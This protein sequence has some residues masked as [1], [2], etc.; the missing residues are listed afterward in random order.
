MI[1]FYLRTNVPAQD[2]IHHNHAGSVNTSTLGPPMNSLNRSRSRSPGSYQSIID[3]RRSVSP[4]FPRKNLMPP[5]NRSRSPTPNYTSTFSAKL[6]TTNRSPQHRNSG[7]SSLP[8]MS[9]SPTPRK[10]HVASL[11]IP[12]ESK[13]SIQFS[14]SF[15]TSPLIETDFLEILSKNKL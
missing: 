5:P 13:V 6:A 7:P 10:H 12:V 15:V 2:S 9:I 4:N 11:H 3:S 8:I 1:Y 14:C